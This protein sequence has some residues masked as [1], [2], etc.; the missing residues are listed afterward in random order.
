MHNISKLACLAIG[1]LSLSSCMDV[2]ST[3]A[4]A[5]YNRHGI[6]KNLH[7]QNVTRQ[8]FQALNYR[9]TDFKDAHIVI[10]TYNNE[11]LLTGQVPK[12]WQKEKAGQIAKSIP[13]IGEVY[14]LLSVAAP[15]SSLTHMSDAWITAKI[16]TRLL[17]ASDVDASHIKVLTENGT[18]YLMGI[19]PVN[20]AKA[21]TE[22]ARKTDGVERVVRLFSYITL[23]KKMPEDV[24]KEPILEAKND[25]KT[26]AKEEGQEEVQDEVD[27]SPAAAK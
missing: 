5:V 27:Q 24:P 11:I 6:Q 23:S 8:V 9:N 13:N 10:A 20:D 18:V 12:A 26:E 15:T 2:A 3:S 4:Q 19:V 22:V 25:V 17:A 7:D 16:K 14:N 21:A 1:V